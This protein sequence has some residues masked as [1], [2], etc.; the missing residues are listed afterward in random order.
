M[1][2]GLNKLK[3]KSKLILLVVTGALLLGISALSA[4]IMSLKH[5]G[6]K[7]VAFSRSLLFEQKKEKI[8]DLVNTAYGVIQE[9]VKISD[10]LD[11]TTTVNPVQIIEKL[12]FG[13]ENDD[14]FWINDTTP[15]MVMHPFKP[16][17]NGK[18]ISDMQDPNGKKIFVE[19]VKVCQE[20]GEGFVEYMWS[21]PGKEEPVPKISYVKLHKKLNWIV[22]SG[23]YIDDI[24]TVM[25]EIE[26]NISA[27]LNRQIW[28]MLLLI[29]AICSII[30][31]VTI[32]IS[33]KITK[34]IKKV[35]AMLEDIAQGEGDLTKRIEI[36]TE[37]EIGEMSGWFNTFID[38]QHDL[39][40]N[41]INN[42][43]SLSIASEEMLKVSEKLAENATETSSKSLNVASAAE[44]MSTNMSGVAAGSEEATVTV[45]VVAT[46]TEE[47][48][49]TISEIASNSERARVIAENAAKSAQLA[50][51]KVD[52]L[53][54]DARKINKVTES[55]TEISEQT[56]LLALNATIEAARAGE[57]GKGFAVVANE[58][59]ELATQTANATEEI[60][61]KIS[62]IQT[63][64][65]DTVNE[66]KNIS[67]IIIE[68]NEIVGTIATAIEE[69]SVTTQDMASNIVQASEGLKEVNMNVAQS[70]TVANEISKDIAMVSE[71]SNDLNIVGV[72]IQTSAKDLKKLS[73]QLSYNVGRFKTAEHKFDIAKVKFAH[74]QWR[75]K[76]ESV[77]MGK[78]DLRPEEVSSHH[79]CDFGKWY[80]SDKSQDLREN[81]YFKQV[82]IHHEKVH[83]YA[84]K[85]VSLVE[86]GDKNKAET[87]MKDFEYEREEL[88]KALDELY[89]H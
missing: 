17:L 5:R 89:T 35:T 83:E 2:L 29:L 32:L 59:K 39:V 31:F 67:E 45:D 43:G 10:S 70:S 13:P 73:Q 23:I 27:D 19:M 28:S 74:L 20:K 44:E 33:N 68:V 41:I 71:A 81:L 14:Y 46:A 61:E 80:F 4:S 38:K 49:S 66:I 1:L 47:M 34:P 16:E 6:E 24:D 54:T 25:S 30:V 63:S 21:K 3:I 11:E 62:G 26:A 76:L 9:S 52:K 37:D 78:E 42:S 7:E 77:L 12:R 18:N 88:F 50:S 65:R 36:T 75:S 79:E 15:K 82:G 40:R 64:T 60:K 86:R 53:G 51:D 85:I 22:G 58:I 48:K 8:K 87:M 55:I 84:K 72:Q 69:Q 56:N 57:A